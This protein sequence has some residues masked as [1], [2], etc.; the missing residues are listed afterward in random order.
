M[1]CITK[2]LRGYGFIAQMTQLPIVAIQRSKIVRSRRLF[3]VGAR[4]LN[5]DSLFSP[6]LTDNPQEC[7]ILGLHDTWSIYG[8]SIAQ[9]LSSADAD[10]VPRCVH[11]MYLYNGLVREMQIQW[12]RKIA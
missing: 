8:R 2:K 12:T 11:C 7:D 9:A 3:N 10:S 1:G 4:Q 5:A 6:R